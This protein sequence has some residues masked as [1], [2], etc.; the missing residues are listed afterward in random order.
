M[1]VSISV[2]Q[3]VRLESRDGWVLSDSQH[4]LS[5]YTPSA[6]SVAEAKPLVKLDDVVPSRRNEGCS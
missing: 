4:D 2:P 1:R 5:R 6:D 3:N